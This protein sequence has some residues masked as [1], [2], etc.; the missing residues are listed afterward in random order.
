MGV[1][2][3]IFEESNNSETL[4]DKDIALDALN[5]S[6]TEIFMISKTITET[7]N[8]QIRQL[9]TAHLNSCINDHFKLSDMSLNKGWYPAYSSPQDQLNIDI[10]DTSFNNTNN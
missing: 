4:S 6:K 8:P 10:N 1:F 5:T 3:S 7:T 2:D 9:L